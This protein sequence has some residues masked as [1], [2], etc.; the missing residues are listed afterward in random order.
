MRFNTLRYCCIA[1]LVVSSVGPIVARPAFDDAKERVFHFTYAGSVKAA[2]GQTVR[3]WLP[4]PPNSEDQK[5]SVVK[6]QLPGQAQTGRESKYG[7]EIWYFEAKAN[8]QGLVPFSVTYQ[9][10]RREVRADW[11]N[12]IQRNDDAA[13]FLKPDRKVPI[14][15][16]PLKLIEGKEL[17]EDQVKLARLLYDVVNQ[18]MRYSKEGT[19]W[20]QGDS[21]WACD[22]KYGNCSDFHSLF[23]S[24][25]RS[26]K[27]PA[28]FEMGFPL[29]DGR[30]DGVIPGYHC[31]AKFKPKGRNWI[32]VDIS[33][34]N[35]N[36]NM[37]EYYF[38]NLTENRVTFSVG[39]DLTL[40]PKQ[41]GPELNFFI[42][43]YAEVDGQ[44]VAAD[45][46]EKRFS[47][48]DVATGK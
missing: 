45:K 24:L 14:D 8:D 36:P 19:G 10:H 4:M 31:W 30:G 40:V 3:V 27:I 18:H 13:L 42:Y 7:N 29:P 20:G 9:V 12:N 2:P 1:L 32:A 47:Y 41:A 21:S 35:K 37:K 34:A 48:A 25:A 43:P 22:S 17:P 28:K 46:I 26:Q 11:Q 33:E 39:R 38:G 15:G 44:P 5:V 23:I 16:K 6:K